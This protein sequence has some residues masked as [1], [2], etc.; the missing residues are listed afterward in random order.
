MRRMTITTI[1]YPFLF[2]LILSSCRSSEIDISTPTKTTVIT[3]QASASSIPSRTPQPIS[4]HTPSATIH[5]PEIT[6]SIE[7][8]IELYELGPPSVEVLLTLANSAANSE[9][10]PRGGMDGI[11][12]SVSLTTI[13]SHLSRIINF[14]LQRSYPTGISNPRMILESFPW[15]GIGLYGDLPQEIIRLL[16][17]AVASYLQEE[18]IIL[19]DEMTLTGPRFEAEA[20]S[21]EIDGDPGPEWL[22]RTTSTEFMSLFWVVLNQDGSSYEQIPSGL[23]PTVGVYGPIDYRIEEIGDFTGDGLTDAIAFSDYY[24]LGRSTVVFDIFQGTP[25]GFKHLTSTYHDLRA[26]ASEFL[27]FDINIS[28]DIDQPALTLMSNSMLYFTF[29]WYWAKRHSGVVGGSS[30]VIAR[31]SMPSGQLYACVVSK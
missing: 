23:F 20:R 17:N 21:I 30:P 2:I 14:E 3:E 31:C 15:K 1:V 19:E 9:R 25:S 7:P 16:E 29:L 24:F 6:G 22:L 28:G 10:G 11:E 26:Q 4:T 18:E 8:N 12:P 27:D 13:M 5:T